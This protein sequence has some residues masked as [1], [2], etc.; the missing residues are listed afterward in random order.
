M[1]WVLIVPAVLVGVVT[2]M[3]VIDALVPRGH[4][5]G[6]SVRLRQT[7]E[8]VWNVVRDLGGV[9]RGGPR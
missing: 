8:S 2:L 9:P 1:K 7:P 6:A 3:A 5:A 4:V